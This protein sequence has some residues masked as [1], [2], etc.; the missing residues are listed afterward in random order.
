MRGICKTKA[1]RGGVELRSDLPV[2][3]PGPGEIRLRVGAAGL[4]G[5]DLHIYHWVPWAASR[6][7]PKLPM[8]LGHE[9]AGTVDAVGDGVAHV[10]P[11]D[12]VSLESHLSCGTCYPCRNGKLHLCANTKYPGIDIPGG[13]AESMVVPARLAWVHSKAIPIEVAAMFEPF[14]IAVHAALEGSGVAGK[15]VLVS[16]C[17]PIGLMCVGVAKALGA[18]QV[19]ATDVNTLRLHAAVHFGA[20][21]LIDV[22][23]EDPA[24]VA[25][26]RTQ[27][28]GIDVVIE[29]AGQESALRSAV[30][31]LTPGG[32]VRLV[33]VPAEAIA[34]DLSAW[35]LKG[36]TVRAIHGRRIFSSWD[37]ASRLVESGKIDLLPL[38]SHRVPL[39]DGLESFEI[40]A[41]GEGVKVLVVPGEAG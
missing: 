23:A 11:G 26:E 4:C 33:G 32:E 27:G 13:F 8:T 2:L 12:L 38:V 24:T 17:G 5:T 6:M 16:G 10:K 34:V 1:E 39:A 7:G 9:V 25:L 37:Q 40:L 15:D 19:L 14:G 30:Q 28:R 31:A 22:S 35:I 41:R 29:C 20:D 3:E 18:S 36:I 21:R